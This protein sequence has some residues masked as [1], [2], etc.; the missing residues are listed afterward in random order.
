M[1][2]FV[3]PLPAGK[4]KQSRSVCAGQENIY[5]YIFENGIYFRDTGD[6]LRR[7]R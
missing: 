2:A 5:I 1:P 6:R 3:A 7:V 4:E